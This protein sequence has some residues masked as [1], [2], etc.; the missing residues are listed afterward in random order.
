MVLITASRRLGFC[1]CCRGCPPLWAPRFVEL[2]QS[3]DLPSDSSLYFAGGPDR[4]DDLHL[5]NHPDVIRAIRQ[6]WSHLQAQRLQL[7]HRG[8]LQVSQSWT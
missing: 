6:D 7:H 3:Q 4:H 8:Q 5:H 2:L 1:R